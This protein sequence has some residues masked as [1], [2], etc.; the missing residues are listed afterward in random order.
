LLSTCRFWTSQSG[1]HSFPYKRN[2]PPFWDSFENRREKI[3]VGG[4][5]SDDNNIVLANLRND[6][7]VWRKIK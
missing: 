7:D 3:L 2:I 6:G 4:K 5:M 1:K